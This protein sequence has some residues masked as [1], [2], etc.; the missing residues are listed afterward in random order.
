MEELSL[1]KVLLDFIASILL[2]LGLLSAG[3]FWRFKRDPFLAREADRCLNR[4]CEM[5]PNN[6]LDNHLRRQ[7]M[8]R[9]SLSVICKNGVFRFVKTEKLH[10]LGILK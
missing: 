2:F 6:H 7:K 3:L 8:H 4:F 9:R 10:D 1:G 5:D